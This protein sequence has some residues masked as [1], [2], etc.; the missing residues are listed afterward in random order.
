MHSKKHWLRRAFA[1]LAAIGLAT[2]VTS[3]TPAA[4]AAGPQP[5]PNTAEA[6]AR[7]LAATSSNVHIF[8]YSWYGN[9]SRNG[10]YRHWP[11]G[12]HTPPQDIGA[13]FYP[14]LGAYDSGDPTVIR[15][16]MAWIR[17]AGVGV[18]VY[19]W[20]GQGS[21][22]DNLAGAVLDAAAEYGLRVAWHL[23]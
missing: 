16:H 3:A 5:V 10:S 11:Q 13:N 8:Y 15:R 2:A 7:P 12:G 1:L 23:E 17:D 14:T 4:Q 9:P 6:A 21:Y 18:L 20:W 22:E 19:S